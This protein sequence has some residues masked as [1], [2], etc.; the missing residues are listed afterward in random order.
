[1]DG[2][3][4]LPGILELGRR[5]LPLPR[6]SR[7]LTCPDTI[8]V[9]GRTYTFN[10]EQAGGLG[11]DRV[12]SCDNINQIITID[13]QQ[14][15]IEEA[16]TVLHEVLHAIFYTMKIALDMDTEEKV[17]SAL[18][19]GVVGDH[20]RSDWGGPGVYLSGPP[21]GGP[22]VRGDCLGPP[23][24]VFREIFHGFRLT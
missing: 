18:A 13:S 10:Y 20:W 4:W 5:G 16:D 8:R 17:V 22:T 24:G 11:Q 2:C 7:I 14:S 3:V 15:L 9:F 19:T 21:A 1:M 23:L 6:K 12:G